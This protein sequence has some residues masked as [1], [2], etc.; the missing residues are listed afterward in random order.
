MSGF[1]RSQ[2]ILDSDLVYENVVATQ[3]SP[4]WKA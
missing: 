4:L 2:N 1:A 3:F